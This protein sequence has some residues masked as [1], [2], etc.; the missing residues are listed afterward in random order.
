MTAFMR[1]PI[2]IIIIV[3]GISL[4]GLAFVIRDNSYANLLNQNQSTSPSTYDPAHYGLPPTIAGYK[5]FAVLT[6]DNTACMMPGEKRLV[7]QTMQ[8]NV[9]RFLSTSDYTAI[10]KDLQQRGF[11][12]F[13]QGNIQIVGPSTTLDQF[14]S[15]NERWNEDSKKYGCMTSG[16][17]VPVTPAQ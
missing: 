11:A 9:Q 4:L 6:S 16:P 5:T 10:E 15:E 2:R 12:D 14:L 8:A 7:L 17:A 1:K 13:A 3:V